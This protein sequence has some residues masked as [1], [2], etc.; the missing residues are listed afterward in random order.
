M[1][2][3]KKGDTIV[4]IAGDDTGT[5]GTVQR[6]F[7]KGEQVVVA[8]VN[9]ITKHQKAVQTG[10]GQVKAGRIEF[11]APIHLSKV[12]LVCPQCGQPTRVGF[13]VNESGEKSRVCKKC[14]AHIA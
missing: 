1:A 11:E 12:M 8:G 13:V 14:Q 3:I 2:K 6:V 9:V 10:R 7:P 5:R 4:V